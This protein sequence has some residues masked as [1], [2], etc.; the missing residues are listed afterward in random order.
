MSFTGKLKQF[1]HNNPFHL[2]LTNTHT[3]VDAH[4]CRCS[5]HGHA[6]TQTTDT[7]T[8]TQMHTL[9]LVI[10]KH[11]K[12]QNNSTGGTKPSE[13]LTILECFFLKSVRQH[14]IQLLL[15]ALLHLARHYH[16]KIFYALW[17]RGT[18]ICT[19]HHRA[20]ATQEATRHIRPP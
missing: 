19:C 5:A 18:K 12:I 4:S 17:V 1:S 3:Y 11:H 7:D 9:R 10:W 15:R 20:A 8:S 2:G 6:R 16:F 13:S 14:K